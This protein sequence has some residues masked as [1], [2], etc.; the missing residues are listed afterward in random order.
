MKITT[1]N[2]FWPPRINS[3]QAMDKLLHRWFYVWYNHSSLPWFQWRFNKP[4]LKLEHGWWLHFTFYVDVITYPCHSPGA[5]LD[6]RP[7]PCGLLLLRWTGPGGSAD[8]RRPAAAW[9]S[10]C[11]GT[12]PRRWYPGTALMPPPV[13]ESHGKTR[14]CMA[15]NTKLRVRSKNSTHSNTL[16]WI[17]S[18]SDLVERFDWS[19]GPLTRYAKL[20]SAHAPGMPGTF[21][22]PPTSKETASKQPRHVGSTYPRWRGKLSRHSRRMRIRNFTYL[23]RGPFTNFPHA[24]DGS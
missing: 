5:H 22:P 23:A 2:I 7:R 9:S 17:G 13:C 11:Y 1:V 16:Y 10:R 3:D 20:R 4:R 18:N 24:S 15:T 12:F 14:C 21:S 8:V 19:L 6:T